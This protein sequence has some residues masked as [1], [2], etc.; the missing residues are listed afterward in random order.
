MCAALFR[1]SVNCLWLVGATLIA[2]RNEI[3]DLI[4]IMWAY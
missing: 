3:E 4:K 2:Q 1:I